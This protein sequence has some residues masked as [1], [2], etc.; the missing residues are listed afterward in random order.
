MEKQ[1]RANKHLSKSPVKRK[2]VISYLLQT[3]SPASKSDVCNAARLTCI[4]TDLGRPPVSND[5]K[6]KVLSFLKK[7][8]ISYCNPGRKDI[9][10]M[11]KDANREKIFAEK[12]YLLW[13]L[14]EVV[15]IFNAKQADKVFYHTVQNIVAEAKNISTNSNMKEDDCRCTKCE[16]L[17]L[18]DSHQTFSNKEQT[19]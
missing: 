6:D 17:E 9:V 16:N 13:N 19:K 11:G 8:G 2:Q 15:S 3:L 7:P 12:Y 10:Y 14:G 1:K 18:T 5:I 4:P